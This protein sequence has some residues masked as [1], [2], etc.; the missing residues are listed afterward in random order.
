MC[1]AQA[2]VEHRAR[3][4]AQSSQSHHLSAVWPQTPN[5]QRKCRYRVQHS[6]CW[7][8]MWHPQA[9]KEYIIIRLL[10]PALP[11][12][13]P[14]HHR[15]HR[16]SVLEQEPVPALDGVRKNVTLWGSGWWT[17]MQRIC[18]QC[19]RL[20]FVL[21]IVFTGTDHN[22]PQQLAPTQPC[23]VIWWVTLWPKI[24]LLK[25]SQTLSFMAK[26]NIFSL[27]V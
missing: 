9:I 10:G 26:N 3:R 16:S 8:I 14:H 19:T 27:H 18:F 25:L 11:V 23:C 2:G 15:Q 21:L 13:T 5:T 1:R 7:Q 6:I 24:V 12:I 20:Q 17:E 22:L 4:A